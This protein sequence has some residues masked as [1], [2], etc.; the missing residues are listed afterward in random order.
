M[1]GWTESNEITHSVILLI[2]MQNINPVP[3]VD[4][5]AIIPEHGGICVLIR[6]QG[7]LKKV[8]ATTFAGSDTTR[9]LP[10]G[11]DQRKGLSVKGSH[12]GWF[13]VKH[14]KW[15]YC[16]LIF[17]NYWYSCSSET[18]SVAMYLAEKGDHF[19]HSMTLS[20]RHTFRY[21]AYFY[22]Y[23]ASYLRELLKNIRGLLRVN[24]HS[25]YRV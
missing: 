14:P 12:C 24:H 19:Q 21:V 11:Y 2:R 5:A 15:N 25:L 6:H 22:V 4:G 16:Y 1:L 17:Y 7:N 10:V 9:H 20:I 23:I 13:D 8:A 18:W 3:A